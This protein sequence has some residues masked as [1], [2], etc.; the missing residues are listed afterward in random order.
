HRHEPCQSAGQEHPSVLQGGYERSSCEAALV[1]EQT[2]QS[3]RKRRALPALP[4]TVGSEHR[5]HHRPGSLSEMAAS[6]PGPR[7]PDSIYPGRRCWH[8]V[9]V[10]ELLETLTSEYPQD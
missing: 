10:A 7:A 8:G 9:F 1:G 5:S 4:T 6:G 3:A 2:Q